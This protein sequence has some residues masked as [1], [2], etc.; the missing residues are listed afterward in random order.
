M[1]KILLMLCAFVGILFAAVNINT[2]TLDELQSLKGLGATKAQAII[3][4]R[5]KTPFKSIDE[6]KNVKG[7]GDKIFNSIKD[8]IVVK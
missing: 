8:E 1:K 5:A 6:I 3:D 2:A 4:Y 7:I